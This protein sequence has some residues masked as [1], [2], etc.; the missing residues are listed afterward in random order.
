MKQF[1]NGKRILISLC[2]CAAFCTSCD[3]TSVKDVVASAPRI[4][5]FSPESGSIGSE[6]VVT[7]EYLDDVT[8]A[9]I[10]GEEVTI[11]QKVSNERL[12][13][14]VT[15]NAKS[16]KI[17]L[18][19]SVGEG[20]SENDF[21]VEYQVPAITEIP[22][23]V[24]MGS[25]L[26]IS[27]SH[28]DVVSAV[29]FTAEGYDTGHEADILSQNE[30]K[31]QVKV[32]YVESDKAAITVRYFDGTS[33]VET[34]V[35]SAPQ[36]TVVRYEPDVTTSDFKAAE[37]GESVTLNG[38]HLD[39]IEKVLLADIECVI[40]SKSETE[41]K[42]E[43]PAS[44]SFKDGDN[45]V[46][47]EIVY[48][49]GREK[50]KLT[51]EFIVSVGVAFVYHWE[52]KTIYAQT[53]DHFAF[54]S[55][56]TGEV[57]SNDEWSQKVDPV[58][59]AGKNTNSTANVPAVTEAEYN[60]VNPYFFISGSSSNSNLAINSPAN[61]GSQLKNFKTSEGVSITNKQNYYG[62]PALSFAYLDPEA[63][64][65]CADLVDKVKNG[66]IEKIDETTF[67]IDVDKKTCAGIKP[68]VSVAPRTDVWAAGKFEKGVEKTVEIDAVLLVFYYNVKGY[69]G[70]D[71]NPVRDV[72]RIG[73]M[74]IKSADFKM[75]EGTEEPSASSIT[76]DMYWQKQDYD[77]SKV[78]Q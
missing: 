65:D 6:I 44:D 69:G 57:Y 43:V 37:V 14:K 55:P 40:T 35:E 47:L 72:K 30:D 75:K 52:N 60:S 34:P 20:V 23:E 59:A 73:L 33:Q 61:S 11:L 48:F 58:A 67:P 42:F 13:L 38:S 27:G 24:E 1:Q 71:K 22:D 54:F 51:D 70:D 26:W 53:G 17:A 68:S 15:D 76:F 18:S 46:S 7:G 21:T 19:N 25:E 77:Y 9:R 50:R 16:G 29:L 45:K 36:V 74:H 12:S 78:V 39:K 5:S 63:D 28:M 3:S 31:I 8:S 64:P 41:L 10:G 56:E 2:A 32:P 4:V 66:K 49:D 62:T